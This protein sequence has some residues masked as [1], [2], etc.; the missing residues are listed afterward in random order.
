EAV[1]DAVLLFDPQERVLST[2]Q[3]ARQILGLSDDASI[4][5]TRLPVSQPCVQAVR[6]A[7]GGIC[8][9]TPSAD[10]RD[11]F[12][13]TANGTPVKLLPVVVPVRHFVQQGHGAVLVL[14]DVTAFA[15]LDELRMELIAVASHE[16]KTPL[17]TL[18]M[19]LLMLREAWSVLDARQRL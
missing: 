10:L 17:T 9:P 13:L 14:Y 7:L 1:P 11:A 12:T 8:P 19:N 5:L 3:A 18:R 15:K 2:N 4:P 6:E 16:L